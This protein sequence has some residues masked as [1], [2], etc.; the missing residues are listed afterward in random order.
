M[1]SSD[2]SADASKATP[3]SEMK[4]RLAAWLRARLPSASAVSVEGFEQPKA[5]FSNDTIVFDAR[6]ET[7]TGPIERRLV[8]RRGG[9]GQAIYP[10]Q[11]SQVESSVELQHRVMTAVAHHGH[12]PVARI[13]GWESDPAPL[14]QPFFVMD[15]VAGRIL[16]DFPS[17]AAEGFFADATSAPVRRRMIESGLAAMAQVHRLDW[18]KAELAWLDRAGAGRSR[19]QAQ[20]ELWRAHL[21]DVPGCRNHALLQSS[22]SWLETNC[23]NESAPTLS[24]G[25]ARIQN[26]IFSEAGDCLAIMDWEGAAILPAEVDL[27]WWQGVDHFVHEASGIAR[28]PGELTP[29]EQVAYY[30][31][32]LG[33]P[34]RDLAY[35]RV[36][37]AFRTVALMISTYDRLAA[38][39][40]T[41]AGSAE[42]NPFERLL[43][44]ALRM[45]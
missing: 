5:G 42:N 44:E 26:M 37:A 15:F 43:E 17:Y 6:I 14:G 41:D 31:E 34:T 7:D 4:K 35:Y 2:S 32:R 22:L 8:L 39:G 45:A 28:L 21:D 20:L 16:P 11:T 23:P 25:D 38:M 24:W 13:F 18:E 1:S 10:L 19:M 3:E 30:E 9:A 33:R 27:A 40:V 12:A 29:E 36:F